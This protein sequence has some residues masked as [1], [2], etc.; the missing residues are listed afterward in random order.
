M[1]KLITLF[2]TV[3]MAISVFAFSACGGSDEAEK[4]TISGNYTEVKEEDMPAL[5]QRLE[6][7]KGLPYDE[8]KGTAGG[9]ITSDAELKLTIGGKT[10]TITASEAVALILDITKDLDNDGL[11]AIKSLSSN[12]KLNVKADKGFG[13]AL[14]GLADKLIAMDLEE[15]EE[16]ANAEEN[17]MIK[18]V[19]AL[20]DDLNVNAELA[21]YVKDS[22]IYANAKLNGIPEAIKNSLPEEASLVDFDALANG[23]KYVLT[24]EQIKMFI[25]MMDNM[26]KKSDEDAPASTFSAAYEEET[27]DEFSLDKAIIMLSSFG[28]KLSADISD[29]SVKL[30]VVIG[31]ETKNMISSLIPM[32]T[33]SETMPATTK[34]IINSINISKLDVELYVAIENGILSEMA[35]KI[36]VAASVTVDNTVIS[37]SVNATLNASLV[38]PEKIDFP[39]FEGYVSPFPAE[40]E[41]EVE[42]AA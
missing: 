4:G 23:L 32:L 11:S 18:G 5:Q 30:K 15:G 14:S 12:T 27:D 37:L 8:T 29:N 36:N 41:S 1:K 38:A 13:A 9:N 20:I 10:L 25:T 26:G 22:N 21:A 31:E 35:A 16:D 42:P 39:S 7:V 24:E 3:I 34:A 40:D 6:A 33:S 2:I 28:A 19:M 17:A